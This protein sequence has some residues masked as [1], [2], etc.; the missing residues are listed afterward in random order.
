MALN[1][2]Q[3][4][5]SFLYTISEDVRMYRQL[6]QLLQQQKA[7]YLQFDGESLGNNIRQQVPLLNQLNRNATQR[8]QCLQRLALP[9]D[10]AG[11]KH[12]FGALPQHLQERVRKQWRAL[13]TMIE[14]CQHLNQSNG[15]S[16]AMLHELLAEMTN[17]SPTYQERS[18]ATL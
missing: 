4:I 17:P 1:R 8:S 16:S 6:H 11:V 5:Q 9:N 12:L 18:S 13:N 2:G 10:P 7:L 15:H 3:L 14:Q